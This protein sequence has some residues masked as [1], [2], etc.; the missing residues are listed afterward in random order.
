MSDWEHESSL[1]GPSFMAEEQAIEDDRE[2]ALEER[3][4][5]EC[6]TDFKP[7]RRMSK[8]EAR[9]AR[10]VPLEWRLA[11][12]DRDQGCLVHDDPAVCELP[13]QAHHVCL[14]QVLRREF[15]EALWNPLAGMGVCSLAHRQHHNR[16]RPILLDEVPV[17]VV[18]YLTEHGFG[19]WL[20]RHYPQRQVAA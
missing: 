14:A 5:D 7:A 8:A 15:P 13:F 11:V 19:P 17:E 20:H 18:A 10:N 1:D 6:R 9:G 4:L 16:V 12:L 3:A 2:R